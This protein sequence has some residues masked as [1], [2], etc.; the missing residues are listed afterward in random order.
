MRK[1]IIAGVIAAAVFGVLVYAGVI[2]GGGG[3][4]AAG[5]R[6]AGGAG[7]FSRPPMTVELAAA[8]RRNVIEH[9]LVVGNLI[10]AATVEV[11][12]K[13]GGRLRTV[14]VR[15]GDSVAEG[16]T[17]AQIEDNEI[18]EQV[19]QAEASF[20]VSKAT[21]RQR[22]AD[23]TFAQTS[24]ER[25]RN[26]YGRQLLPKQTL[27][28]SEARYQA[29]VAQLDLARAQFTQ[30]ASRVEEL[31]ITRANTRIVSP[32]DGFVGKRYLDA[33]GFVSSNTPVVSVVDI[34]LVR[35]VVNLVEKDLRR[36]ST[37]AIGVVEV[38]AFPGETFQ[39]RVARIAPVLDPATRTAEIEIEVP[40]AKYRLKPGMYARVRLTVANRENTLVVPRNALMDIEGRRGVFVPMAAESARASSPP[41]AAGAG[42]PGGGASQ[43]VRF[44]QLET[45]IEDPDYIE[46]T[47]GLTEGQQVVT[48]GAAALRD[49]DAILLARQPGGRTGPASGAASPVRGAAAAGGQQAQRAR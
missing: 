30:A 24:L 18:V 12:P 16:Q 27:D 32:V 7:A 6:R 38:D 15:L 19:K 25:S 26:L 8:S 10:G 2:G 43:R 41:P 3:E 31:R 36:V 45:G 4:A 9:L 35:L 48:T 47:R 49:G 33:G 34:H 39:G 11:V 44:V 40:N 5:A 20:E 23:L 13:V 28:D 17:I 14:S 29:A 1:W 37:G 22:E 42:G 46:V 21:I